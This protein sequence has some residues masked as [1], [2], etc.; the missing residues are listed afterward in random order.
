M[1][2]TGPILSRGYNNPACMANINRNLTFVPAEETKSGGT[3]FGIIIPP[4]L[5]P[6]TGPETIALG[7][8]LF[9]NFKGGHNSPIILI[10][11]IQTQATQ[12]LMAACD[13]TGP[14]PAGT[15]RTK[16]VAAHKARKAEAKP[17]ETRLASAKKWVPE[18]L[19]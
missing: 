8:E 1:V 14:K 18:L 16:P 7:N 4:N 11:R 15:V 9:R 12:V 10:N 5:R 3:K 17:D 19:Y 6:K 2:D 13:D